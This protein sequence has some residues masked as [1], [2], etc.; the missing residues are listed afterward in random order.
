LFFTAFLY[1]FHKNTHLNNQQM[2]NNCIK[3]QNTLE[4]C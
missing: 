1:K 2:L 3:R 4:S